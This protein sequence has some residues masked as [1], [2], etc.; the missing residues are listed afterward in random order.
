MKLFAVIPMLAFGL[1]SFA[2][3]AAPPPIL[4]HQGRIAVGG[5]NFDGTGYF[6]FALVDGVAGEAFWTNDGTSV[7]SPVGV[8]SGEVPVAVN[9]GHYSVLL[10]SAPMVGLPVSV[11]SEEVDLRLRVWFSTTSGSGFNLLTPDRRI[12]P[13]GYAFSAGIAA[14]LA[15]GYE[16]GSG[17][18]FT[19]SSIGGDGSLTIEASY[20]EAFGSVPVVTLGPDW[21]LGSNDE[22]GF[23]ASAQFAPRVVDAEGQAGSYASLAL[24]GGR[25][26][27][28]YREDGDGDL[29]FA[30]SSD[31]SGE[32]WPASAIATVAGAGFDDVGEYCSLAEVS[33]RPAI[34]YYDASHGDLK[35]LRANDSSGTDWPSATTVDGVASNTGRHTSLAVV[36]GVPAISYISP[37][38]GELMYA[39]SADAEGSSWPVSNIVAI[40]G[41]LA[42]ARQHTALIEVG[43]K[44]AIA[45][46]N[47]STGN[48]RYVYLSGADASVPANWASVDVETSGAVSGQITLALVGGLPAVSYQGSSGDIRYSRALDAIGSAW[49][50]V[51]S[52]AAGSYGALADIEGR[53]AVSYYDAGAGDLK[54]AWAGDSTGSTWPVG[55]IV[56][57]DGASANVGTYSSLT[58]VD[59]LPV[60]AYRDQS[61]FDL[62]Y[63]A[64][65]A[66]EWHVST[67]VAEPILASGVKDGG[68]TGAMLADEL[69][70]W[71]KSGDD[72]FYAGGKVGVGRL[73]AANA[74]EVEGTAS[75]STAGS[76]LSN[77]DRRIKTDI[78]PITG[79]L[80][81]IDRLNPVTFR[82]TPDYLAQHEAIDDVPYYNV[83]AQEFSHVFPNAVKRSGDTTEGGSGILQVDTYPAM[84]ATIAAVKELNAKLEAENGELEARIEALE[85]AILGE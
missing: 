16:S 31:S 19:L 24:V 17:N 52:V 46:C 34:S 53:P 9:K 82:Y 51:V 27:V 33:G 74:L 69:G 66:A 6:K 77:S 85:R 29:R 5:T 40:E 28:A 62:K 78:Q 55:N 67:G 10:G 1:T 18:E 63:A 7:G 35:F 42:A 14:S 23:I 84:I 83:V 15:A 70:V 4:G 32:I 36:G 30:R 21:T 81:I 75:K 68:V 79:A 48:L 45:S 47:I 39:W 58:S 26:A 64:L 8:P 11:F 25:P 54:F 12:T 13:A 72:L 37:N 56:T 73:A 61:S 20:T 60:I 22:A 3:A 44:P 49:G 71:S 41:S 76:W 80:R 57:V 2:F 50:S 59:G 65:P 38:T 43:G